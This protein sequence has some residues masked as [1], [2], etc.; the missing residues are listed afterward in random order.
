MTTYVDD[1]VQN[2]YTKCDMKGLDELNQGLQ[3]A[4][5][6]SGEL[7]K[8]LADA[9]KAQRAGFDFHARAIERSKEAYKVE[10]LRQKLNY[11]QARFRQRLAEQQEV[12]DERRQKRQDRYNKSLRSQ[13]WLLRN[14]GRLFVTY[15]GIRSLKSIFDTASRIQLVQK[16]IQG[17]TK[18]TQD[19]D[20]I[21]RQAFEKG[22]DLEVVAKGYRNFYSSA[23]MAGFD[24]GG[25]QQMYSDM[26]LSTRAIGASTQQ[27]EGALLALEQMLSKGRVSMEELRRQMGNAIP[28][29]FEIGARAMNMT[30]AEF[31]NFVQKVGIASSE[32]VPKFI[33]QLKEEYAGGFQG[34]AETLSFATTRLSVAWKLFQLE[35]FEGETGKSFARMIDSLAKL[36]VSPEF[37]QFAKNLG[38]ILELIV[39]ILSF[40]ISHIRTILVLIGAGGIMA[41]LPQIAKYLK[42]IGLGIGFITSTG[43]INGIRVLTASLWGMI[44]PFMALYAKIL[45]VISALLILEDIYT[46]LRHPEKKSLTRRELSGENTTFGASGVSPIGTPQTVKQKMQEYEKLKTRPMEMYSSPSAGSLNGSLFNKSE[47]KNVNISL[48]D[49]NVNSQNGNPMQIAQAVQE[50]L[51]ALFT[52]QGLTMDVQETVV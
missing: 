50:Q 2:I 18:D 51:V 14:A 16:S 17:L 12:I 22:V 36:M 34:I 19:W 47:Q 44:A 39:K 27:T 7:H 25:I 26:L 28:G 3:D 46:A 23:K 13:N 21:Q 45:L 37:K 11:E 49:I 24:K 30:T 4:I 8:N 41:V 15:F 6:Y 10:S 33:K 29:A 31:N 5:W 9:N 38:Q 32:F 40:A 52:G 42:M 48:G 20:Y 43:V 35:L 1:I